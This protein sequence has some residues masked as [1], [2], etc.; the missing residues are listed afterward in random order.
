MDIHRLIL[1]LS[2]RDRLTSTFPS[3]PVD[4]SLEDFIQSFVADNYGRLPY[5]GGATG[6]AHAD[7][8]SSRD[9]GGV[10][11]GGDRG[12]SGPDSVGLAASSDVDTVSPEDTHYA[13][14]E[15]ARGRGTA[16]AGRFQTGD[17]MDEYAFDML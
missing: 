2:F 8:S 17:L 6:P 10:G 14:H 12:G 11:R 1:S 15:S 4:D 5:G 16:P 3:P 9:G 13:Q 7:T